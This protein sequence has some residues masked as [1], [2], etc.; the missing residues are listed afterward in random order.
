MHFVSPLRSA[1][2]GRRTLALAGLWA[3]TLVGAGAEL[4]RVSAGLGAG[5][6]GLRREQSVADVPELTESNGCTATA[7]WFDVAWDTSKHWIIG[8]HAHSLTVPIED[9]GRVGSYDLLPVLAQLGLRRSLIQERMWGFLLVGAG[10]SSTQFTPN[11]NTAHWE[12]AGGGDLHITHERPFTFALS[13]GLDYGIGSNLLLEVGAGAVY[14]D[15][16]ITYQRVPPDQGFAEDLSAEVSAS[17][18]LATIGIRWWC[19]W[20]L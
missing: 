14:I 13:A 19:D 3:L 16:R 20:W 10:V 7:W 11:S 4:P 12:E 18:L 5:V 1:S 9:D 6:G 2:C 17:H 15:S 8:L